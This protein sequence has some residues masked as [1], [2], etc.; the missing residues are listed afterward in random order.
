[1][2]WLFT[3]FVLV[4]CNHF[5]VGRLFFNMKNTLYNFHFY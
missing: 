2:I 5:I 3:V 4:L 1:M